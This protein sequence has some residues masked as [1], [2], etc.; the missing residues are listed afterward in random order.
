LFSSGPS[1]EKCLA[2]DQGD[3]L[4]QGAAANCPSS[5]AGSKGLST[6]AGTREGA[7]VRMADQ[8]GL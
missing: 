6:G 3:G 4:Q 8:L 1:G 2:R 5:S 7:R